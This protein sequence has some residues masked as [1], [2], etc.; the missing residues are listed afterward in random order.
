MDLQMF[1]DFWLCSECTRHPEH[2]WGAEPRR[3]I[4]LGE[5]QQ[6]GLGH[7]DFEGLSATQVQVPC[8]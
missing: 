5:D 6:S 3:R 4:L 8:R 7:V 2:G 1:L